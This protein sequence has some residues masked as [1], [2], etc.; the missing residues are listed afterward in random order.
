[1]PLAYADAFYVLREHV[2]FVRMHLTPA[3]RQ[4][5]NATH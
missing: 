5:E 1:M 4:P 2:G 3:R